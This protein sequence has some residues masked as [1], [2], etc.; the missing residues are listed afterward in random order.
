MIVPKL[1]ITDSN[2]YIE[3]VRWPIYEL[4]D[5]ENDPDE[6]INLMDKEKKI[7]TRL[8]TELN[9]WINKNIKEMNNTI[10]N[11]PEF[12]ELTRKRL[13]ALGYLN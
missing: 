7:A 2:A 6:T 10:I 1:V 9:D 4:Y 11:K 8:K 3:R 12:D 5:I 13:K